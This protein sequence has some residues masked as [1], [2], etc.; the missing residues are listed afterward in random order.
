MAD[1]NE[2]LHEYHP[3]EDEYV[4]NN[5]SRTGKKS[6]KMTALKLAAAASAVTALVFLGQLGV[7]CTLA[8][9]GC[10]AAEVKAHIYNA[11]E[12]PDAKSGIR[13]ILE[14]GEKQVAAGNIACADELLSFSD[15]SPDTKYLLSFFSVSDDFT[16]PIGQYRFK[17]LTG[18]FVLPAALNIPKKPELFTS[19]AVEVDPPPSE[20]LVAEPVL[21]SKINPASNPITPPVKPALTPPALMTSALI[22]SS[23]GIYLEFSLTP[24]DA[25]NLYYTFSVNGVAVS[26]VSEADFSALGFHN[27][28]YVNPEQVGAGTN[29]LHL[30]VFYLLDGVSQSLSIEKTFSTVI[31]S[32]PSSLNMSSAVT[33]SGVALS[34]SAATYSCDNAFGSATLTGVT[35][36][37]TSVANATVT[38][39]LSDS[40]YS[41][42]RGS[43]SVSTLPLAEVPHSSPV[44]FRFIFYFDWL[45][46]NSVSSLPLTL[47]R[48]VSI[49]VT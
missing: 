31:V 42:N 46:K 47:E 43:I 8:S 34:G 21:P 13:Y 27:Y 48:T 16:S 14:D 30:E 19:N 44:E 35:V 23:D 38:Q 33:E 7:R 37:Y 29:L 12:A 41:V 24:N 39:T 25:T 17:T 3:Y 10:D 15:L 22:F 2:L 49:N 1:K 45:P 9:V 26:T 18:V 36:A 5:I 32:T 6:L 40:E 28:A 4:R 20:I 11:G